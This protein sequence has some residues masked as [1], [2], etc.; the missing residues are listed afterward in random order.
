MNCQPGEKTLDVGV[1]TCLSLN[2]YPEYTT[3]VGVDVSPP[4]V[5]GGQ[6]ACNIGRSGEFFRVLDID[7]RKKYEIVILRQ[8]TVEYP[9]VNSKSCNPKNSKRTFP[10]RWQA[11]PY[12]FLAR[13]KGFEPLTYGL[14]VRCS[15]QL[16]YRRFEESANMVCFFCPYQ[17][18]WQ[19][20]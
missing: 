20:R 5:K 6:A 3:V 16:S 10:C 4:Y 15:I 17:I 9:L 18:Q 8:K 13:L 12:C 7:S 2:F 19:K 11:S 1:G 14:E